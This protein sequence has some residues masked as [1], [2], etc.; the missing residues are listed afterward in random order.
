MPGFA[1]Q[2][3]ASVLCLHAGQ[4]RPTATNPRVTLA[5][6]AAVGLAALWKFGPDPPLCTLPPAAGGPC[7][8]AIWTAGSTRVVSM[9]MPLVIESGRAICTPTSSPLSVKVV[10]SRVRF[11]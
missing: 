5:G 3:G 7:A 1:V 6:S 9:G 11:T 10:Q 2:D 4:A 8:T